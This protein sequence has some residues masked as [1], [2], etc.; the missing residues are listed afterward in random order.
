[1]SAGTQTDKTQLGLRETVI[2]KIIIIHY[3]ILNLILDSFAFILFPDKKIKE[4]EK[5]L[6]FRTGSL[7]DSVCAL[8]AIYSTRKNFPDAQIDILTNAGTENL[9][10]L[11]AIIDKNIVNEILN[12]YG[13][14]KKEL[15]NKLRKK[16]I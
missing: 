8:P 15:F 1:M 13:M 9:V 16:K 4:V 7:G 2:L 6:I 3:R 10:S 12:Y 5:I 11:G 14:S